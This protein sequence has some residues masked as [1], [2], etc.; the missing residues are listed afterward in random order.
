MDECRDTGGSAVSIGQ[1]M[2]GP[3]RIHDLTQ[4]TIHGLTP[5]GDADDVCRA[6]S[7]VLALL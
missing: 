2:A 7:T 5:T 3:Y 4:F 1:S 6:R